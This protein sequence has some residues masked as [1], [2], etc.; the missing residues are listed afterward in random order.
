M[1]RLLHFLQK[2]ALE[3][4]SVPQWGQRFTV[5]DISNVVF[6]SCLMFGVFFD[7]F[8]TNKLGIPFRS[9]LCKYRFD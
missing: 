7:I 5:S 3:G 4:C 1:N 9:F 2:I 8:D 6:R